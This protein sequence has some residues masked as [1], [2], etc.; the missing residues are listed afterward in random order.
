LDIT[1]GTTTLSLL[2]VG[3]LMGYQDFVMHFLD[4][5]LFQD[6]EHIHDFGLSCEMHKLFW[7]SCP[8]MSFNDFLILLR[9]F[10]FLLLSYLF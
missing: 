2:V 1:K 5:A 10:F 6:M 4:E 3:V 7:A 8:H 9:Q